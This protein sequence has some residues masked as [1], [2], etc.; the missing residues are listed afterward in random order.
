LGLVRA[1]QGAVGGALAD[2]WID[3]FT[4]PP[5][6]RPTAALFPAVL[7]GTNAGRG[8]NTESSQ[9]VISNGSKIVVPEGYGL[10]TVQ[11]G[12]ITSFVAEPGGYV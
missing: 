9:A 10:L 5:G 6:I 8:S 1:F 11:D 2:Q 4:V 7:I 3:F 12:A